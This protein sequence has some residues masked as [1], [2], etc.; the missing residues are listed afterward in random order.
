MTPDTFRLAQSN[1][2]LSDAEMAKAVGRSQNMI[3]RYK[4]DG[5]RG[6][7]IPDEV[8]EKVRELLR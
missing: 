1:L 7:P 5:S 6:R 8:A 3:R 4:S 2:G